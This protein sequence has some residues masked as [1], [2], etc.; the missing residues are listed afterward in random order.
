MIQPIICILLSRKFNA[1]DSLSKKPE[2]TANNGLKHAFLNLE[3]GKIYPYDEWLT[4]RHFQVVHKSI[5]VILLAFRHFRFKIE[6][7]SWIKTTF[8][9][10]TTT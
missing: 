8:A 10:E 1:N 3:P 5:Q 4:I 6:R 7:S 9:V 2:F